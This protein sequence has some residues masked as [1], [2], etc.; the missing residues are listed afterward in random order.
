MVRQTIYSVSQ[1][2]DDERMKKKPL[3]DDYKWDPL[4]KSESQNVKSRYKSQVPML[5]SVLVLLATLVVGL[6]MATVCSV[7]HSES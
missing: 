6:V 1:V 4:M 5:H 3:R 2:W 7:L